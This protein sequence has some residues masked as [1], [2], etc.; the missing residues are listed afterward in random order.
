MIPELGF[1]A[2]LLALTASAL[3]A[4][5]PLFGIVKKNPTFIGFAWNFS[6]L[7]AVF[8][9]ISI[10][11]LAYS[12][13]VDDFSV[14]YVA[15]HSNSQLPTFFKIAATWGGHEGSMLFWLFSL[16][17][18]VASFAAFSRKIDPL[19][20]ARSLSV[21]GLICLA[22]CLFIIFLS[23]PFIRVFPL[24]PEGRDLNPMLQDVGLIFHPPLLY[25]GY[26]GFAVNFAISVAGL[27]SGHFDAAIARWTRN[28]VL[29]SWMFLTLGIM[30]GSWWAYY[31]LGWGGWWFWDPVE[32]ASLM[33]WLLGLALLHSLSVS[34]QRG[35]FNYWTILFSLLAFAFSLLGTFIVRSGVLTSVHAFAVDSERGTMLLLLFFLLTVGSLTLFALKVNLHQSAVRFAVFSKESALLLVNVLLAIATVSVFLGTFYP[36]LYTAMGWGSIS[37]GAPYFNSIFLPLFI[38]LLL[39]MG[40]MLSTKWKKTDRT[41]FVKRLWLP[42]PAVIIAYIMIELTVRQEESLRFNFTAFVLLSLSLW[43]LLAT[44]W[45][46]WGKIS[47]KRL[48]MILAHCGVAVAA[49]GA[50]MSSY[51]G[52]ELG[53]RL[54]P[55]QSQMLSGYEFSY[56]SFSNELGPNYTAEKAHFEIKKNGKIL[57]ALYPER[58]HYEVRTMNM[59]E[60]GIQWG[61]LGDIYIVMGDKTGV[62]EF[63][64]RLHYKPFIRWLW[65]GGVLM[66]LG[67]LLAAL[68]LNKKKQHE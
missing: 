23:N 19:L 25:L 40:L 2:L 30:L 68:G 66:A 12:F 42:I 43:L 22:F 33:P 26:V 31:E 60:V 11:C 3:L 54:A 32:N 27:I 29:I 59:S 6:Y 21:L 41:F 51:F 15:A 44:L 65:I 5:V 8:T 9:T 67:A 63:A 16:S 45:T 1:L 55:K 20:A 28:W 53:V 64:F 58:R 4:V 48:G 36:M 46:D 50:V 52:S 57:T 34:E 61:L 37:V 56:L 35:I 18:W 49:I 7:F 10:A 13:A 24:P 14:E 47:L 17:V 62:G 38:L 39:A